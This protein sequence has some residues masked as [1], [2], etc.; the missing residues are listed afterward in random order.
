MHPKNTSSLVQI[1]ICRLCGAKP[2]SEP[3]MTCLQLDIRNKLQLNLNRTTTTLFNTI[4]LKISSAKCQSF[5]L[6]LNVLSSDDPV[7]MF[8]RTQSVASRQP[9]VPHSFVSSHGVKPWYSWIQ[10]SYSWCTYFDIHSYLT[11]ISTLPPKGTYIMTAQYI[12]SDCINQWQTVVDITPT[13]IGS[14]W[15]V[16]TWSQCTTNTALCILFQFALMIYH[17]NVYNDSHVT[18]H[19]QS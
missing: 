13:L 18:P 3:M 17:E 1:T 11:N 10:P 16:F 12:V 7:H 8:T 5:C 2:L 9:I 15:F 4:N 6:S 19:S 14:H